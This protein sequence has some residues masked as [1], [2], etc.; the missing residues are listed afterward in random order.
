MICASPAPGYEMKNS[1]WFV[2]SVSMKDKELSA[3]SRNCPS[4]TPVL[5]MKLVG[6]LRK[7][8]EKNRKAPGPAPIR[9][10]LA[11]FNG[12]NVKVQLTRGQVSGVICA[13][14]VIATLVVP[15][16]MSGPVFV[17][18][19]TLETS[20]VDW[21][22]IPMLSAAFRLMVPLLVILTTTFELAEV[23]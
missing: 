2:R 6:L 18:L 11:T 4:S 13:N 15:L 5:V 3:G 9:P 12:P 16:T 21:G 10:E 17:T 7:K 20:P 8:G 14:A 19:F 22:D 1:P 23:Q